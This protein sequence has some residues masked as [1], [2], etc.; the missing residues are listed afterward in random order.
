[1]GSAFPKRIA[2]KNLHNNNNSSSSNNNDNLL[3]LILALVLYE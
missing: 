2:T 3:F 1:M